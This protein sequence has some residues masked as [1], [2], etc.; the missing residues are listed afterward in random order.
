VKDSLVQWGCEVATTGIVLRSAMTEHSHVERQG[1]LSDSIVG[2]NTG[3]AQ[4]E[5]TAC[6]LGPFVGFHHQALLIAAYWPEGKGNVSSGATT[7]RGRPARRYGP[8][9]AP[10]SA[11]AS[12]SSSPQISRGRPTASSPRG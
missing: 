4:G 6:L 9:K 1:R 10:S 3:L 7:R 5:A 11:W 8:A 2:P 12:T